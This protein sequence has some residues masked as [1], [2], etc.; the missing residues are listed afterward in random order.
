MTTKKVKYSGRFGSRY[1]LKIRKRVNNV[2]AKQRKP[3]TCPQ[4]LYPAA[5]RVSSG[6]FHCNKCAITFTGGAYYPVTLIGKTIGRIVKQ[7]VEV[8]GAEEALAQAMGQEG[9]LEEDVVEV[10]MESEIQAK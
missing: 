7:K 9:L 4:C 10:S 1:G 5:K 2:E 6:L 8:S 3:H